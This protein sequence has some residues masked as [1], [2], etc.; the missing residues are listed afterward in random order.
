[1]IIKVDTWTTSG[2]KK[3]PTK[4]ELLARYLMNSECSVSFFPAEGR[5]ESVHIE[6]HGE[7]ARIP[8]LKNSKIPGKNFLNPDVEARLIAMTELF[9]A[10]IY[11]QGSAEYFKLKFG[12]NKVSALVICGKRSNS[13]DPDNCLSS[14]KDWLEPRLMRGKTR[15]FG[16]GLVDNDR[17]ITGYSLHSWQT[18]LEHSHSTIIL[19]P[20]ESVRRDAISFIKQH[21]LVSAANGIK[22][23]GQTSK[24]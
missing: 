21:Y 10:Q 1:M 14:V 5:P 8:S 9:N 17:F 16:V 4:N 19:R 12:T 3:R 24:A 22:H 18:G 23:T 2:K 6:F 11:E 13:F 7:L 20:W 15:S